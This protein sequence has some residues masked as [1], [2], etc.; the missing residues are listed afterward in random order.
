[1]NEFLTDKPPPKIYYKK[2][3]S[4]G[5]LSLKFANKVNKVLAFPKGNALFYLQ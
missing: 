4:A 2:R 5:T 3:D 1:M